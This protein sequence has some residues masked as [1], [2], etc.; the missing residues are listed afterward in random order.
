[1]VENYKDY[2]GRES[3]TLN[4]VLHMQAQKETLEDMLTQS[5][6]WQPS[7]TATILVP[8]KAVSF[9]QALL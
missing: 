2:E 6:R 4:E 3:L 8:T 1:L 5:E 7:S 9:W